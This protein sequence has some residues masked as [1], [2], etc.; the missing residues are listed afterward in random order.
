MFCARGDYDVPHPRDTPSPAT[1][2]RYRIRVKIS[3][4]E[5]KDSPLLLV[6]LPGS[7]IWLRFRVASPVGK[8]HDPSHSELQKGKPPVKPSLVPIALFAMLPAASMAVHLNTGLTTTPSPQGIIDQCWTVSA[9]N[10]ANTFSTASNSAFVVNPV[11]AGWAANSITSSW[12]SVAPDGGGTNTGFANVFFTYR[13]SFAV[14]SLASGNAVQFKLWSDNNITQLGLNRSGTSGI[15]SVPNGVGT[16]W[17]ANWA[18]VGLTPNASGNYGTS[19]S[20]WLS[21]GITATLSGLQVGTNVLEIVVRNGGNPTGFR[22]EFL[23][24][25]GASLAAVEPVPEPFTLGLG[26]AAAGAFLRHRRRRLL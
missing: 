16:G 14:T 3:P 10:G 12:I 1:S 4:F 17:Q 5:H 15:V 25:S 26:A 11:L 18:A 20:L 23:S 7:A 13:L 9:P 19:S 21:D 2:P 22:A 6:T 24:F 8:G